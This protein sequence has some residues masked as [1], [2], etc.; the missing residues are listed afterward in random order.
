MGDKASTLIGQKPRFLY[1]AITLLGL[2]A[3]T[4]WVGFQLL[5]PHYVPVVASQSDGLFQYGTFDSTIEWW[6]YLFFALYNV[7]VWVGAYSIAARI[8][9]KFFS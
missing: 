5:Q 6:Q 9:P 2:Y 1:F 7:A 8:V 3:L 4:A